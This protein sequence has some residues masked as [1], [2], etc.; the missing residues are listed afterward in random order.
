MGGTGL[1]YK[2]ILLLILLGMGVMSAQSNPSGN[3]SEMA[4]VFQEQI[5]AM[6][7]AQ[8]NDLPDH[9]MDG[10]A[11][12]RQEGD[13][14][15]NVYFS[16]FTHVSMDPG[17]VLDYVY[18]GDHLGG[19]P[20]LYARPENQE[21][22]EDLGEFLDAMDAEYQP[23]YVA[24]DGAFEYLNHVVVDDTPESYLEYTALVYMG[25]QFY[26]DWHANYN[27]EIV[28]ATQEGMEA[29]LDEAGRAFGHDDADV[30]D[31]REAAR[32]LDFTPTVDIGETQVDVH[33]IT[34]TKWGGFISYTLS[35]QREFP[36]EMLEWDY[37]TL[38]EYD[39]GVMF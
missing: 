32:D 2:I 18:R 28:I 3:T 35:I 15:P 30:D 20:V 6:R 5:D 25:D 4:T 22:Y 26:L 11:A 27:D 17:Y 34:F 14:D 33:F 12:S 7:A 23:T 16:I 8:P 13:F 24:Q 29:A 9:F 37:E 36:H 10:T 1:G 39:C 31:V 38:I 21:P 19:N